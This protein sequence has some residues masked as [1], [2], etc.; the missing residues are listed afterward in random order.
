M[1]RF[2]ASAAISA[3]ALA[4]T[5]AAAQVVTAPQGPRVEAVV[6]YDALRVDLEDYGFDETLK[7][8]DVFYGVGAGYDFAVSPGVSAG[9]D[10]E[11]TDSNNRRDFD[12]G[13]ENVEISTG[14]DFYA[15]GRLTLPISNAANVYAKAG[16]TNLKING[17]VDGVDDSTKLDGY[18]LG[19]G[20][21]FGIGGGAYVG[22]EYRYS[23]YEQDLSRH[24]FAVT[25]GTRF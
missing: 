22:G 6:G 14:R 17:E 18:R 4:A 21:Q 12:D 24:Q 8:N 10:V 20:A 11:Y 1:T 16:Y 9:V 7:D 25:L 5:P 3:V 23:D 15:G 19:A 2:L 13:E